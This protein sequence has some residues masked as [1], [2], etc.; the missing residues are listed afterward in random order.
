MRAVHLET[1]SWVGTS[2]GAI[3]TYGRLKWRKGTQR[4][5]CHEWE[6][7]R[8]MTRK[9]I[10]AQNLE[11]VEQGFP[12]LQ[13]KE[14]TTRGFENEAAVQQAAK[15]AAAKLFKKDSYILIDGEPGCLSAQ[16]LLVYPFY[17]TAKAH[18]INELAREWK[19]IGGY[20]TS[21]SHSN[22]ERDRR[23][24]AIDDEWLALMHTIVPYL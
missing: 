4:Y 18:R 1:R 6:L 17:L 24:E 13:I 16:A 22:P 7:K 20:G 15:E 12:D 9:E 2:P 11:Y 21:F 3:H 19:R 8:P 5:E 10:K 23:A 14:G